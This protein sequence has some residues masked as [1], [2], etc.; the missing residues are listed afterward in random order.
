MNFEDEEETLEKLKEILVGIRNLRA[1]MN[2]ANNK[3]TKLIIVTTKYAK[4]IKEATS[5]LKRLGYSEEI[6]VQDNKEGISSNALSI[7]KDGI[8]VYIPL[9]E[10]VNLE[11]EKKRLE[12]EKAKIQSEIERA[13]KMLSNP[14]FVNKA[15]ESKI[16]EEKKKL[17]KYKEMLVNIEER[18]KNI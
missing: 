16:N 5:Y 3:K 10:L 9:E 7:L 15:P 17:E 2:V 18:I 12:T 13:S 4:A 11:E 1:G 8:E 14:G 6:I